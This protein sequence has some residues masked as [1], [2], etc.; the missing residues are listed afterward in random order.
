M[1]RMTGQK[2]CFLCTLSSMPRYDWLGLDLVMDVPAWSGCTDWEGQNGLDVFRDR[3]G[4]YG[5]KTLTRECLAWSEG[6]GLIADG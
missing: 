1:Q 3:V 2:S 5:P 4:F 6:C